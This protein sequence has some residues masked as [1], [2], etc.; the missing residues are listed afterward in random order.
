MFDWLRF[1]RAQ[2]AI[3]ALA[4]FALIALVAWRAESLDVERGGIFRGAETHAAPKAFGTANYIDRTIDVA[5]LLAGDVRNHIKRLGGLQKVP[6][7]DLQQFVSDKVRQTVLHDYLMVVDT[8]GHPIVLS[9]RANVPP[10]DLSDREWFRAVM[11]RGLDDYI[12]PA[13]VQQARPPHHLHL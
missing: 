5:V 8:A 9:E 11:Q 1:G 3:Y 12:G 6:R 4:A 13:V 2:T 10:I 7:S